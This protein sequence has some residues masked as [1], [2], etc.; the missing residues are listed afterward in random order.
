MRIFTKLLTILLITCFVTSNASRSWS[1]ICLNQEGVHSLAEVCKSLSCHE[2]VLPENPARPTTGTQINHPN[3]SEKNCID[4][5]LSA[6]LHFNRSCRSCPAVN[7]ASPLPLLYNAFQNRYAFSQKIA[8]L[9][10]DNL[11]ALDMTLRMQRAV[12]LLI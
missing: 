3:T 8:P 10:A 9:R 12:V 11:H 6:G 5:P 2:L 4:L 1:W 7:P